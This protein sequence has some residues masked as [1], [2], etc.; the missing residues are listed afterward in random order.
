MGN[1]YKQLLDTNTLFK[2]WKLVKSRNS[3]GGIDGVSVTDFEKDLHKNLQSLASEL[4]SR[5][6]MPLPYKHIAVPKKDGEQRLLGMQSVRD[7]IVQH[8]IK[9]LIEPR[10]ERMFLN[11]SYGYRPGKSA[12]KA[13]RRA[14]AEGTR[15]SINTAL[16][17]DIDNFFDNIDH[18]IL[19]A[20]LSVLIGDAE[21]LRLVMLIV[22][23]GCVSTTG[24]WHDVETGVPQGA[25]LSPLLANVY[26][27]SFDQF[28]L[29][30]THSYIRYADDFILFCENEQQAENFKNE[31]HAYLT[32]RLKLSLN[33]PQIINLTTNRYEF[34]GVSI[35]RRD[36]SVSDT[37]RQELLER[38]SSFTIDSNGLTIRCKKSWDGFCNYYARLLP[39][40]LL[41]GFDAAL[42]ARLKSIVTAKTE[43]FPTKKSLNNC[44]ANIPFLS[45]EYNLNR[46]TILA[47]LADDYTVF[48]NTCKIESADKINQKAIASRR[49]EYRRKEVEASVLLVNRPGTFIGLTNRGV[50]VKERGN[51]ISQTPAGNLSHIIIAGKG[52]SL[53]SNLLEH[54]VSSKI[55]IDIFNSKGSHIGSF[56]SSKNM[57]AGLWRAQ[58]SAAEAKRNTLAAAI[59]EGK[60]KNQFGLVK[61]FHKYHKSSSVALDNSFLAL[62][63]RVD[64]FKAFIKETPVD[65][66][67]YI[68]HLVGHEAQ[69][70][71][72]YWEYM[73]NLLADDQVGFERRVH[74]GANDIVNSM[75][76]YGYSILYARVWQALLGSGLNPYESIIHV[77]RNGLPTFVYDVIEIFRPQAVDRVVI[78]MIQ[79]GITLKIE[80]GLLDD[81]TRKTTS[82]GIT[83]RLCR[84]EKFRGID[85]TLNDII[86]SQTHEIAEYYKN[87][88][89]FKP[90]ISKW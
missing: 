63:M 58:A 70:A 20:R 73:R 75:L 33:T 86:I 79:K 6:W 18:E 88:A 54:C 65:E 15:Q 24:R 5:K 48:K 8:A 69:T 82:H 84:Y 34:L 85:M 61:Y 4:S 56:L 44:L 32:K 68:T 71:L 52:V 55:P 59:V 22:K 11:N 81:A 67:N 76:N 66:D 45:K 90:Y 62:Q 26:L 21:V 30:R 43:L 50:T 13:I 16:R 3:V 19:N 77:R 17:L 64:A 89:K 28:V 12:Y 23:M 40:D 57:E 31:I 80:K 9:L 60:I 51:V 49:L 1:L 36:V 7:K 53:S 78:G 42:V 14:V 46:R 83:A 39:N 10:C 29:S 27:H 74:Q 41:S 47:S 87:N 35:N 72:R 37:K 2:A 25:V 38:I